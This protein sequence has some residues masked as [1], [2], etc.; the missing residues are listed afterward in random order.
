MTV[1]PGAS[2]ARQELWGKVHHIWHALVLEV[3]TAATIPSLQAKPPCLP[4]HWPHLSALTRWH[5]TLE[6]VG[7]LSRTPAPTDVACRHWRAFLHEC[8]RFWT[9]VHRLSTLWHRRW[10]D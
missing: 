7:V 4:S 10:D 1:C 3:A 6:E 2:L 9:Q 5:L 8:M